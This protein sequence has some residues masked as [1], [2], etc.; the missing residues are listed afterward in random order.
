MGMLVPNLLLL[1]LVVL[2]LRAVWF[3]I[4]N[5]HNRP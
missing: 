5:R 1:I 4:K 2:S 3:L